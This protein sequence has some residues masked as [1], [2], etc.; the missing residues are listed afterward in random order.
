MVENGPEVGTACGSLDRNV[1]GDK[2]ALDELADTCRGPRM[3]IGLILLWLDT[4]LVDGWRFGRRQKN[5]S[6]GRDPVRP[7]PL[8][9]ASAARLD[10]R[11]AGASVPRIAFTQIVVFCRYS[12][13]FHRPPSTSSWRSLCIPARI[14]Q[15]AF[16]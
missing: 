2:S 11:A 10:D 7:E 9:I 6:C 12:L 16:R 1:L 14:E 5:R 3:W 15:I 13:P 8:C 4:E